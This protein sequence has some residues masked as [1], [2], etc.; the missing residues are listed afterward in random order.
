MKHATF[1]RS[2]LSMLGLLALLS[3]MI[4]G[5]TPALPALA[6]D[7]PNPTAVTIAGSLQSEL[8]YPRIWQPDCVATHLAYDAN[9]DV[10][11]KTWT[12]P[13]GSWEYKAA[14]NDSWDENYGLHAAPGGANIP[15]ALGASPVKFYYDHKSHWITDNQELGHR[16]RARQLPVRARLP[17]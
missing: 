14:L 1:R 17:G 2:F 15:L 9:D 7:T 6:S 10:W 5:V 4:A 11:Q 12:M 16:R 8:A 3:G 13:A